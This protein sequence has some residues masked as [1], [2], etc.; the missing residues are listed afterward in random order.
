MCD[1]HHEHVPASSGMLQKR[2]LRCRQV[3]G[4]HEH[5]RERLTIIQDKRL[6]NGPPRWEGQISG[7]ATKS[8]K[9]VGQEKGE[10]RDVPP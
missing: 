7:P 4:A 9:R 6:K 8:G 5:G 1:S 3:Q 10:A 2:T